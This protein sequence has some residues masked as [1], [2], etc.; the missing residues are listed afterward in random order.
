MRLASAGEA[1]AEEA[2]FEVDMAAQH[3]VIQYRPAAKEF[4]VLE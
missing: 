4:D 1:A 2:G 3:E